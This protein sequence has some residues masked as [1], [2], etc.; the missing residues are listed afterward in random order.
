MKYIFYIIYNTIAVAIY[1]YSYNLLTN[2]DTLKSQGPRL[3]QGFNTSTC[4]MLTYDHILKQS[5]ESE[6]TN[7]NLTQETIALSH[8]HQQFTK[9]WNIIMSQISYVTFRS[10]HTCESQL[11]ITINDIAKEI[12]RN[13]QV[14]AALLEFL[15][16]QLTQ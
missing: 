14:D 3:Y 4:T 6:S 2:C 15:T 7:Y 5:S 16:K 1:S 11:F 9:Q 10:K 8:S 12:D 13:L